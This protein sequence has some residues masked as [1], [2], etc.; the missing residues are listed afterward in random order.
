[1]EIKHK[2][3]VTFNIDTCAID[4]YSRVKKIA[5]DTATG[6]DIARLNQFLIGPHCFVLQPHGH[7]SDSSTWVFTNEEKTN[8][9]GNHLYTTF[10][11][12]LCQ[13]KQLLI[14][15]FDPTDFSFEYLIQHAWKGRVSQC[16]ALYYASTDRSRIREIIWGKRFCSDTIYP[17]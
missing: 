2:G 16:K 8:L 13:T 6:K 12:L 3:I 15:G 4:S 7:I 10:M 1:M 5:V 11:T 9:L 14:L 17:R